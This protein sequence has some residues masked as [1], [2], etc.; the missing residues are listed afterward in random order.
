MTKVSA[1][2]ISTKAGAIGMPVVSS[3]LKGAIFATI[4]FVG[5]VA[6]VIA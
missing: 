4:M 1:P 5:G 3:A 6:W 2:G